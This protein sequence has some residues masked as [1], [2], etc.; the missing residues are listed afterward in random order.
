VE[1]P[2]ADI[3]FPGSPPLFFSMVFTFLRLDLLS[4]FD[5]VGSFFV[6]RGFPVKA[7]FVEGLVPFQNDATVL[8]VKYLLSPFFSLSLPAS[9]LWSSSQPGHL[10]RHSFFLT[11][12]LRQIQIETFFQE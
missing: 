5:A 9:W 6:F 4:P 11:F 1:H 12:P 3:K 7:I 8:A 2:R 10:R